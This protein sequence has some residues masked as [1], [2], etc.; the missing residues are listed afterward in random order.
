MFSRRAVRLILLQMIACSFVYGQM[1]IGQITGTITDPSGAS[2]A[3]ARGFGWSG[4]MDLIQQEHF[5][6]AGQ[7]DIQNVAN[8]DFAY[9]WGNPFP[10]T[11]F[12]YPR[13]IPGS[14][15]ITFKK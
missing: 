11:H 5:T 3:N 10:G 2:V 12:G 9:N 1:E 6:L 7:L 4:G 15:K 8:R 14:L 13:L